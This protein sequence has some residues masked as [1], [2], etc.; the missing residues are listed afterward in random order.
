MCE[1]LALVA[2]TWT[3]PRDPE[4]CDDDPGASLCQSSLPVAG[5]QTSG[6]IVFGV[7]KSADL[8][9]FVR[10]SFT[11]RRRVHAKT[12]SSRKGAK[13]TQRRKVDARRKE[14]LLLVFASLRET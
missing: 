4:R 2:A 13:L 6:A 14:I 7:A 10:R 5:Q 11:Q 12:Q 3:P 9:E 8:G 1:P